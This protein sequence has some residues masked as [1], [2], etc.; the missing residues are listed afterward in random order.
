MADLSEFER[1]WTELLNEVR[2]VLP[3]VQLLFAFLL[4][5]PFTDRFMS[6]TPAVHAVFLASFLATTGACAFLIAPSVYHRWHWRRDVV[7]KE[8]MIRTCNRLAIVGVTLLA[9]A[10]TAA[11]FV[12]SSLVFPGPTTT[13]IASGATL[14]GFGWLWFLLPLS[15]RWR[16]RSRRA[17][18]QNR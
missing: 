9:L 18:G 7:D 11:V 16:D 10:M 17:V 6:I 1:E 15:R 3:G 14:M 4:T 2:V 8:E 12:F 13:F 5:A